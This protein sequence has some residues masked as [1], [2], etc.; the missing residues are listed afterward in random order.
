MSACVTVS[1]STPAA[2][3]LAMH[4]CKQT[5]LGVTD[6]CSALLP[7]CVRHTQMAH[8]CARVNSM[9]AVGCRLCLTHN[10]PCC[11]RQLP[12]Y[13]QHSYVPA[14]LQHHSFLLVLIA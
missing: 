9:Q 3:Y 5:P 11:T 12:T 13:K 8:A 2:A 7:L 14:V 1:I 4:C 10:V 6:A